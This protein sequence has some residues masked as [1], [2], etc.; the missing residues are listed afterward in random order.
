MIREDAGPS[1]RPLRIAVHRRDALPRVAFQAV[2]AVNSMTVD[3][4]EA[5]LIDKA[6]QR[7]RA[8][9]SEVYYRV[10]T[11]PLDLLIAA[12]RKRGKNESI[13]RACDDMGPK[14]NKNSRTWKIS[15]E[16]KTFLC[17]CSDGVEVDVQ[18]I[19]CE[20]G[21]RDALHHD[22]ICDTERPPRSAS[23]SR[24]AARQGRSKAPRS[25]CASS[26]RGLKLTDL[27]ANRSEVIM[28][29]S[30]VTSREQAAALGLKRYFTGEPCL[31]GHIAGVRPG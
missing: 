26:H 23:Q 2:Q 8:E 5:D 17:R 27:F 10:S 19:Y 30:R 7:V 12:A 28:R 22:S 20:G 25:R 18:I 6:I 15:G 11:F 16:T 13:L 31:H 1:V 14:L 9:R 29:A 24:F 4:L 3:K 21:G